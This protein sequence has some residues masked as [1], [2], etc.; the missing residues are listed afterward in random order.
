M[1]TDEITENADAMGV[2]TQAYV[3]YASSMQNFNSQVDSIQAAYST[4]SA[5]QQEYNA[6]GSYSLDTLQKLLALDP[7]YLLALQKDG[8]QVKLN[9]GI[10]SD[11]IDKQAEQAKQTV[12]KMSIE[13]LEAI[14]ASEAGDSA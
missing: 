10:F 9:T 8:N 2:G 5:A 1:T 4:L 14:K 12:Y 13:E 11:N 3:E 6:N 7:Q